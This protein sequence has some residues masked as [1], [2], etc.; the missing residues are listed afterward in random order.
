MLL[1]E[2]NT[3]S[4]EGPSSVFEAAEQGLAFSLAKIHSSGCT[5]LLSYHLKTNAFPC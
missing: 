1:T 3:Y 4:A 5:F 2:Q